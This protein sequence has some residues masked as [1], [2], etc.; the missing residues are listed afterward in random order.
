[1]SL[2]KPGKGVGEI[3]FIYIYNGRIT[4]QG[5]ASNVSATFIREFTEKYKPPFVYKF[6]T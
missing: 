2:F 1:M 4:I 6:A 3:E 5:N